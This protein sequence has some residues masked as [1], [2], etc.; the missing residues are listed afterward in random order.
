MAARGDEE[1]G[2]ALVP[3]P[4]N[5]MCLCRLSRAP[6]AQVDEELAA[7]WPRQRVAATGGGRWAGSTDRRG[8]RHGAATPDDETDDE[9]AELRANISDVSCVGVPFAALPGNFVSVALR[10]HFTVT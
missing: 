5:A 10:Y 4:F 1:A 2:G 3:C 8:A 7:S 6:G 9:L